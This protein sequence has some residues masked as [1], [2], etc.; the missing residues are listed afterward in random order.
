M[1]DYD[2]AIEAWMKKRETNPNIP[3]PKIDNRK[4][5]VYTK[6]AMDVYR[7]ILKRYKN[8]HRRDEVLFTMGYNLY[9]SGNKS[10]GVKM[11]WD[12]IKSYPQSRFV[13]D[14]YLA[15]GEHFFNSNDVFKAKKAYERAMAVKGSKVYTYALYKLAW[16]D[17]NLGDYEAALEKFKKV[18]NLAGQEAAKGAGGDRNKI[19]LKREALQDM[20][21][22]FSQLDALDEAEQYWMSQ[23]GKRGTLDYMRKLA[24]TYKKQGKAEMTVKAFRR[25]LDEYPTEP[26]CPS[27]HNSI[28]LAYRKMNQRDKVTRE[29]NRIIEQY[30]PGSHWWEVNKGNKMATKRAYALVEAS[31]RD[32]VTSY[33]QEAQET[34]R[35]DT[36]NLA[37][38]L[39]AKY[40]EAFPDSEY[41]Y[42]LRWYYADVL[43]KM[44]DFYGAAQQYAKVV[45]KDPRGPFS[46][47]AAYDAVLSWD[48]CM[49]LRDR[50]HVDCRKW[51]PTKTGRRIGKEEERTIKEERIDFDAGLKGAR[52]GTKQQMESQPI[53][54]FEKKFLAAADVYARVAPKHDMYIPIRFKSA[55]IFYKYRHYKE[56]ARRFGEII[57]RYPRNQFA[58][59]AVRLS[60]NT[61]YIKANN[62]DLP[63]KVRTEHWKEI[64]RWAKEFKNNK[65]LMSS[66]AARKEKFAKEIQSLIEESGYN[67]VLALRKQD[68]L[69]AAQGFEKFVNDYPRSKFAHRALYAA[70]IIFDE[71]SQLDLAIR[72]GKRLLKKYPTSDRYNQTILALADYHNRVADFARAARYNE[73][74]FSK[75]QEQKGQG[76]KK[77]KRSRRRRRSR[78][79][80]AVA[81]KSASLIT[82]KQAMDALYNA[83]LLRESMGQYSRAIKNY[84]K[85]INTHHSFLL[86]S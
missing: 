22:T 74:F 11:Y 14:A 50:K 58:L 34:K 39:Y 20:V 42:K 55:F 35:W 15:M 51:Q 32:L 53:P 25:L 46:A 30:R 4:S 44:G 73:M 36:Y 59:K 31:L 79:K 70:M 83:A 19:Q 75:W 82:D 28:V 16:C 8:Y 80:K 6:Q 78:R 45:E 62:M 61:M 5:Q 33:H 57:E 69:K 60:L 72:A 12:L 81:S 27:Y 48:K 3:E 85:Y 37:R 56:M 64:N 13:A 52:R 71:A 84:V 68:P 26:D 38:K 1:Q 43:Y 2:K 9:E 21:L 54:F 67:V 47:E 41:A 10:E 63:E 66:P 65:V 18:V 24:R 76:K 7:I 40:M 49:E 77:K 17:Y 86:N 29:I 23:V